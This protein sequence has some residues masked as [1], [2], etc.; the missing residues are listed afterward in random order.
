MNHSFNLFFSNIPNQ[1]AAPPPPSGGDNYRNYPANYP[2]QNQQA[3]PPQRPYNQHQPAAIPS[4]QAAPSTAPNAPQGQY[5][6]PPPQ[7]YEYRPQEQQ[8]RRHPDFATKESQY[9]SPM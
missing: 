4:A 2:A 9:P 6:P 5:P 1:P 8:A 7:Q 3:L